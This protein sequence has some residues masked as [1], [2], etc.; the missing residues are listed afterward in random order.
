MN[1]FA[2]TIKVILVI[3]VKTKS[4]STVVMIKDTGHDRT[5]TSVNRH[6]TIVGIRQGEMMPITMVSLVV[7]YH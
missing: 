2:T 7:V 4:G 5:D 6:M 1:S 3:I